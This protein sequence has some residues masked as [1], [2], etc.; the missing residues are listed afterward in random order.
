MRQGPDIRIGRV[1]TID[2]ENGMIS[3]QYPD[4]NGS[5]TTT[6]P[7][8]SLNGEYSMPD[9]DDNVLVV[10]LSNGSSIG[11]VLGCFWNISNKPPLSGKNVFYKRLSEDAFIS[12]ENGE[13]LIKAPSVKVVSDNETK[14]I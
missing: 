5:V 11:I 7:V 9:I 8:L 10:Y 1:S 13:L 2:Y 4:L 6:M 14:T 12:Y 3:V